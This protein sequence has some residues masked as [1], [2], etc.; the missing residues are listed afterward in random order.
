MQNNIKK[1]QT[2]LVESIGNKTYSN[3]VEVD[4][5]IITHRL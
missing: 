2:N 1:D 5:D 4:K 3:K